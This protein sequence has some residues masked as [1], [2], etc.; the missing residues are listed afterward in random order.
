MLLTVIVP[1]PRPA[2]AADVAC[3]PTTGFTNCRRI[4]YSGG[5]QTYALPSTATAVEVRAWGAAGGG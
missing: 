5:D 1:T 2:E 4:T 3:T